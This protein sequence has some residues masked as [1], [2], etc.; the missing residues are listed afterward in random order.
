MNLANRALP[1]A[2]LLTASLAQPATGQLTLEDIF[3]NGTYSAPDFEVAQWLEGGA[4]L[5]RVSGVPGNRLAQRIDAATGVETT[6]PVAEWLQAAG[7]GTPVAWDRVRVSA[8]GR[9]VLITTNDRRIWRRSHEARYY[10]HDREKGTTRPLADKKQPQAN[11]LFSPDGRRLAYV[12]GGDLYA[13]DLQRG[14]TRRLS[15]DGSKAIINGQADW[16]YE[17]EFSLTRAFEWSPDSRYIAFLRFDQGHVRSYVLKDE[18]GQYP[19][20]TGIRYP[21][22]GEQNSRVRLGVVEAKRGAVRWIDLGPEED[23]YVPRIAWTGAEGELAFVRLDRVQ[24]RLEL[25]IA[26]I[27]GEEPRVAAT[28]T[29]PAWVD[30]TDDLHFIAGGSRFVWTTEASG[31]RHIELRET[32]GKRVR[33]LTT[34]DWEVVSIL[35]VDEVRQTVYFTGKRDGT[36]QEHVYRVGLEGGDVERLSAPGGWNTFALAPD[37]A[38]YVQWRSSINTPTRISL[39]RSSGEEIRILRDDAD[40]APPRAGLP[41]WELF[42]LTTTDGTVLPAKL[43]KPIEFAPDQAYPTLIYTYGGPGSQRVKDFWSESRGRDLWHRYLA[44]QAYVILTV[45]NRGTG[46][47]GKAFKNLAYGDLG[48]WS[49]HDQVEA[50]K[51]VGRQSWGD[52]ERIG[53]WGWSGGGYLTALCLTAAAEHF[54]MGI[55]VAPVTD[56]RLYDT[57]WTE[58][59]MGLL[60]ENETG[61]AAAN[62]LNHLGNYRGGLLVIH[63]TGDDNV[64]PQHTWQLVD[65]LVASHHEFEM[66]MYPN[67]DHGLPGTHYDLY[68]RMTRFVRERL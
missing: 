13:L 50:T 21:K 26:D 46:G 33:A 17:E 16:L 25:V 45:D 60:R 58:R 53:I 18:L 59:Y 49:V 44:Q 14:R 32:G 61:Y 31:Y 63:G 27:L 65:G 11:A 43:L 66:H 40:T 54:K 19:Q 38:H 56:F 2:L 51:W 1:T 62:V 37:F 20:L 41:Q 15:K 7:E 9:W 6:L 35:A 3:L 24:Q 12:M 39:H 67:K 48:K 52:P 30:L 36:A 29:D 57:A 42:S 68:S 34:G 23:I 55:A 4:A 47:K 28:Q 5:L 22:V 8:D 10:L 64:H